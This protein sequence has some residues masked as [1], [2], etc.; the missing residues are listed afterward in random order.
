MLYLFV[1]HFCRQ[2][3]S[4][5]TRLRFRPA[6]PEPKNGFILACSHASHFDPIC[7]SALLRR[8]VYWMARLEFYRVWWAALLLRLMGAFPVN[9]Y[10]VPI[11]ALKRAISLA[12]AEGVVGVFVEGE[13][14]RNSESIFFGGKIKR[15]ACLIAQRSGRPVVPCVLLGAEALMTTRRYSM[16]RRAPL[17]FARGAPIYPPA[18]ENRREQRALMA[19]EIEESMRNLYLQLRRNRTPMVRSRHAWMREIRADGPMETNY[20]N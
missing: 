16:A 2:V 15:G 17:W 6:G 1:R 12:A 11:R 20:G 5:T 10:G 13:V 8:R 9:R 3:F 19:D 14:K 4:N 7:L 18:A